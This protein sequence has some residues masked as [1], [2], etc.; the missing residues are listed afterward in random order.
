RDPGFAPQAGGPGRFARRGL[1]ETHGRS[2]RKQRAI[3]NGKRPMSEG[4]PSLS[5]PASANPT[6]ARPPVNQVL[7]FQRLRW[8]LLRNTL[9]V[10]MQG[11]MLRVGLILLFS[12]IIWGGIF[13]VSAEAFWFLQKQRIPL[14]GG[15]VGTVFD[16]LFLALTVLLLFSSG[17]ILYS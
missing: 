10:T 12:L 9:H 8:R 6:V 7:L 3:E 13:G 2:R 11:S 4:S 1:F 14:T 5:G 15:I 17:I 16:L